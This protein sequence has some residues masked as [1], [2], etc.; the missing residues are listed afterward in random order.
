MESTVTVEHVDKATGEVKSFELEMPEKGKVPD[1]VLTELCSGKERALNLA[2]AYA[3]AVKRQAEKYGIK[4]AALN[5]YVTAL[6]N[7]KID[8]L[9]KETDQVA[10]LLAP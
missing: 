3:D 2:E 10:K 7:D 1:R 4:K 6:V 5:R 8:A 9:R